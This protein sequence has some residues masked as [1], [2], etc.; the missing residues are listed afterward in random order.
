MIVTVKK[1]K[2]SK[3]IR[4]ISLVFVVLMFVS[5]YFYQSSQFKQQE[6]ENQKKLEA[7]KIE[8]EKNKKNAQIEKYILLEIEKAVD[9]VGQENVTYVK[10][11]ENKAVI[12]CK[13]DV[14]LE[15]LMVR[16]GTLA[17][18]KQTLNET[19]I[20]LDLMQIANGLVKNES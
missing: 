4:I 9:L 8:D 14:N 16:Y 2:K 20:A 18:I 7:Q 12:V 17:L 1:S 19:I 3:I 10:I 13:K 5:Y 11:I 15:A 6:I